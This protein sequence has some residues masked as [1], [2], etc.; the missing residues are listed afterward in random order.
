MAT[1][2]RAD[3]TIR[4]LGS[5]MILYDPKSGTF[6]ILNASARSIWMML[7]GARDREQMKREYTDLY[8]K[9]SADRLGA[10]LQRTIDDLA[11]KG[12]VEES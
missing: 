6:H 4:D 3:L 9:E 5:E 8:P 11:R 2:R 10:D 1:K 12:L 7:D